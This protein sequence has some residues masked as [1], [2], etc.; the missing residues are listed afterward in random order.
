MTIL[1]RCVYELQIYELLQLDWKHFTG[2]CDHLHINKKGYV[3]FH[4]ASMDIKSTKE[5]NLELSRYVFYVKSSN[6]YKELHEMKKDE[7]SHSKYTWKKKRHHNEY[8][9]DSMSQFNIPF[10]S[11]C[12]S[13]SI[14][15]KSVTNNFIKIKCFYRESSEYIISGNNSLDINENINIDKCDEIY[16]IKGVI[17]IKCAKSIV[18]N[19]NA[20][21]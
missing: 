14:Y 13:C 11:E 17:Q 3:T 9:F 2:F 19:K 10:L 1:E 4:T 18:I 15:V 7:T 12:I 5:I 8:E 6:N 16:G 20:G 21:I